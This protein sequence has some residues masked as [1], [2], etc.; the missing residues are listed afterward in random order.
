MAGRRYPIHFMLGAAILIMT[1]APFTAA[2]AE[3]AAAATTQEKAM[4]V[5]LTARFEHLAV[6]V[7]EP[8]AMAQWYAA[9]LGFRI[10]RESASPS[11]S[12]FIADSAGHMM[13]EIY[14]KADQPLLDAGNIH[15]MSLHVAFV[16]DSILAVKDKLMTAGATVAEDVKTSG[17]GDRVVTLRD[18]WGLPLQFVQR[19]KPMLHAAGLYAEHIALNVTDARAKAQWFVKNLGMTVMTEG[20]A[21]S[22]GMFIADSGKNMMMELYQN[23][24]FPVI[25]FSDVNQNATHLAFMVPDIAAAKALLVAAGATVVEDILKTPGGDFVLMLRDPWGEPLQLV[26]RV[27]P[28][29]K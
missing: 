13:F 18:P 24:K 22:Y 10:V 17:S 28:M 19:G 23:T 16:A 6:N 21:P 20:K 11:Y 15:H 9:N 1:L 29:L 4:P 7:A 14:H 12:A 8:K 2:R 25:N 27:A 3:D 26:T 5:H